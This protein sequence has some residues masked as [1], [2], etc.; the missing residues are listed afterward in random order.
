M[1]P[2]QRSPATTGRTPP[3]HFEDFRPGQCFAGGDRLVTADDL[4]AFARISGDRHRLHTDA[5]FAARQGFASPPLHGPFGLATFFGWYHEL[6][7]AQTAGIAMLD[8]NWRYLAPI[9]VG[10]RLRYEMTVTRCRRTSGGDKGVVGRH[11]RILNQAGTPVQD[12]TTS[13]LLRARS[14][15]GPVGLEILSPGWCEALAGRLGGDEAF[16]RAAAGLDGAIGLSDGRE[17]QHLRVH[18]GRVLA[19]GPSPPEGAAVTFVATELAWA[20]IIGGPAP[21]PGTLVGEGAVAIGGT[22]RDP[23]CAKDLLRALLTVARILFADAVRELGARPD[24]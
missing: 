2:D 9:L 1:A 10:D 5:E 18:R 23:A 8:T 12:G 7:H 17:E 13:L 19:A 21:D 24:T 22:V 4:A 3:D 11:V 16:A 14:R 15:T 6:G 20:R